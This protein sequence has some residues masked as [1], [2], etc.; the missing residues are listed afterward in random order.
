MGNRGELIAKAYLEKN[1]YQIW[2]MNIWERCGEL[3]IVAISVDHVL[4]FVEV[5]TYHTT[6][7]DPRYVIR[8]NKKQHLWKSAQL[9]MLKNPGF[10]GWDCRFDLIIVQFGS[11]KDHYQNISIR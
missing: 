3:D 11:V 8:K 6:Y 7:I 4:V 1:K 5:K 9:F 10:Q 2:G